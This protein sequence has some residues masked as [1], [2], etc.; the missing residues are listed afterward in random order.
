MLSGRGTRIKSNG[1][2]LL[3][4]PNRGRARIVALV[5]GGTWDVSTDAGDAWLL[6]KGYTIATLGMAVGCNG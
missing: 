5:D 3:E 4:V 1:S 2:M 6:R